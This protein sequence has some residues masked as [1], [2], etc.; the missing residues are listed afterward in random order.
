MTALV[1][2]GSAALAALEAARD[3]AADSLSKSTQRAYRAAWADFT[4]YCARM[5]WQSLPAEPRHVGAYLASLASTHAPASIGQRLAAIASAHRLHGHEWD[6]RHVEIVATLQGM[7]KTHG[8][9]PKRAEAILVG[10]LRALVGTCDASPAGVRDRAMLLIGFAGA[11]RRSEIVALRVDD[12]DI[13]PDGMRLTIGRS[14]TD[15]TGAGAVLGIPAGAGADTCPVSAVTTWLQMLGYAQG[16]LFRRLSKAGN[17]IG[18][19]PMSP[20]V[21]WDVLEQRAALAGLTG[22][23]RPHGLRAG[24]IT[25]AAEARIPDDQIMA[26]SRHTDWRTMRGYIRRAR[27]LS[28]SPAGMVG[29]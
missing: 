19:R 21:V 22:E 11:L 25:E 26:H 14:K 5:G 1:P 12:V 29:L 10:T 9:P 4:A 6:G 7:A 18:C 17:L 24:F 20:C 28:D 23:L 15:Q 16:P 27:T 8:R 3:Y 2:A 13:G